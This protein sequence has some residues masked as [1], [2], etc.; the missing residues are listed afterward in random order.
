MDKQTIL[1]DLDGTVTDSS[2]GIIR[3]VAYAL[4][5]FGIEVDD[6]TTL[7]PFIGPPLKDAFIRY[8]RFDDRQAEQAVTAYRVYYADKGI[9]ENRV[10]DGI[11]AFLDLLRQKGRTVALAT[12]KPT[13]FAA[14]ILEHFHLAGYFDAVCGSE[15]DGTRTAKGEVIRCALERC[16]VR[17]PASAVM[18]GDRE[19]DIVG[20]RQA[21][22]E[23]V[24]VLYGYGSYEEL[25]AS[26]ADHLVANVAGLA[27]LLA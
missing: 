12:S 13:V 17:E 8:Y 6:L 22:V 27:E 3:S 25:S 15:L 9:F 23:S 20:A 21:G 7:Y 5:T 1:L 16:G 18:V 24:G 26:G 19:H 10:Y 4:K 11:P 14:R 2:P